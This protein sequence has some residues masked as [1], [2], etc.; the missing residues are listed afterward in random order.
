MPGDQTILR[1]KK[2]SDILLAK[3]FGA[4]AVLIKAKTSDD[5]RADALIASRR[6]VKT[7]ESKLDFEL[8]ERTAFRQKWAGEGLPLRL[9]DYALARFDAIHRR[10][11]PEV[12]GGLVRLIAQG[13]ESGWHRDNLRNVYVETIIGPSGTRVAHAAVDRG[14]SDVKMDELQGVIATMCSHTVAGQGI[15]FNLDFGGGLKDFTDTGVVH[16][17]PPS[18]KDDPE[19]RLALAIALALK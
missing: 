15:L 18:S 1:V 9:A 11:L 3:E 4:R 7:A 14:Y 8:G 6:V 17:S 10:I 19:P 16:S 5:I 2:T 13:S 12:N